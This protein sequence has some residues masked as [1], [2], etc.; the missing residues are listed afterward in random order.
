MDDALLV[1]METALAKIASSEPTSFNAMSQTLKEGELESA[2]Y[3]L[4]RAYTAG[5]MTFANEAADYLIA[6]PRRLATG[7]MANR[8]WA[9][10]ELLGA[11]TPHC[12][13]QRLRQL[14][15]EVLGYYPRWERTPE[16]RRSHGYAQSVLLEGIAST[17]RSDRVRRRLQEL[18]RKFGDEQ[19]VPPRSVEM[20]AVT[21]PVPEAAGEK[22]TDEQWLAAIAKYS[23]DDMRER[24]AELVGGVHELSRVLEV[25]VKREPTRFAALAVR[26]GDE[27]PPAYFNAVLRGLGQTGIDINTAAEVCRRVHRLP[28]RP[29]G[30]EIAD[31]VGKMDVAIV[32]EDVVDIIAWYATEDADPD[33]QLREPD[34]SSGATD[35]RD[36]FDAG[37]NSVRGGAALAIAQLLFEGNALL[38]R[39][40]PTLERMVQDP[41][42]AVRACV[43]AALLSLLRHD[44][45]LAVRLFQ[46]LAQTE[47]QFLAT[48]NSEDFLRYGL[49]THPSDLMPIVERMLD[50]SEATVRTAGARRATAL[51]LLS[52]EASHL[53]ERS[54]SG[55][56]ALRLGTAQVYSAN[57][58]VPAFRDRCAAALKRLFIDDSEAVRREAASF[59]RHLA[60]NAIAEIGD[61]IENFLGSPAFASDSFSLIHVLED[62]PVQLPEATLLVC[63]RFVERVGPEAGDIRSSIAMESS[64]VAK[65]LVRVYTQSREDGLRSRCLDTIDRMAEVGAFGLGD[66]LAAVER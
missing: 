2:Q 42:V 21:S 3:L 31:L 48:R 29:S 7:Y 10:R 27:T 34:G 60:G 61:L 57:L 5:G 49:Q 32:P 47:D 13:Q 4:V 8:F 33:P 56:E 52:E 25:Q 62:A 22:M 54:L 58:S 65:L 17:R 26:F 45:D 39:L 1:A 20:V 11:I 6:Q 24:G 12:D 43:A 51:S 30:R 14:E 36:V 28:G 9:G 40:V 50:S 55:D 64:M 23:R 59:P 37:L 46:V 38:S 41:S 53:A 19:S 63:D 66:V 44:R 16:G 15:D 18:Q 35:G